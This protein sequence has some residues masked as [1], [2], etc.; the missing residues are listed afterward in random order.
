MLSLSAAEV[1][2][3]A[4]PPGL[5]S[6]VA[7]SPGSCGCALPRGET[8]AAGLRAAGS[9]L[10]LII[11]GGWQELLLPEAEAKLFCQRQAGR[12]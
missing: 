3:T 5:T 11:A 9:A 4:E 6:P 2:G 10:A 1:D 8:A 7:Q 12:G